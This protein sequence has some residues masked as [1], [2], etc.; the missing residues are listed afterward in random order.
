LAASDAGV[1]R[2]RGGTGKGEEER[3]VRGGAMVPWRKPRQRPAQD[4]GGGQPAVRR[5]QYKWRQTNGPG[6][7]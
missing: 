5:R 3:P 6:L 4:E 1:G 2:D 7:F